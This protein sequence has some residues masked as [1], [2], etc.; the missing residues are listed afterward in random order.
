VTFF[1]GFLSVFPPDK[2]LSFH[3]LRAFSQGRLSARARKLLLLSFAMRHELPLGDERLKRPETIF[4]Y[5]F[6]HFARFGALEQRDRLPDHTEYC[7]VPVEAAQPGDLQVLAARAL[8]PGSEPLVIDL[9]PLAAVASVESVV[10]STLVRA[11]RELPSI[12]ELLVTAFSDLPEPATLRQLTGLQSLYFPFGTR[13]KLDLND[14]PAT[15]MLELMVTRW[16]VTSLAP[17]ERMTNLVSLRAELF[18][19]PLDTIARMAQLRLLI[20]RG[21]ARGWAKL[22][23]CTQLETASFAEVDMANLKRWNTW[24]SLR[25]LALTGRRLRSLAGLEASERL[26]RLTLVNLHTLDLAMLRELPHLASLTIRM[27]AGRIDLESIGRSP[28]LR[29]L[30]IDQNVMNDRDIAHVPTLRDLSSA[31]ALEDL[32]LIGVQVDDRDLLPL[33][34]LP[35]LRKV[36][37]GQ[38]IGADVDALRAARPELEVHY[39]RPPERRTDLAVR[40]GNVTINRP[41]DGIDTWWVFEDLAG[42]L[43][44]STNY[45]AEKRIRSAVKKR[46]PKLASRLEWDT[47]AGAVGI[48]AE[49][50]QDMRQVAEI[51]NDLAE[52]KE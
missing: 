32:V 37:L 10:A 45:A 17:L 8:T 36:R 50:E 44:T 52:R 51:V 24:K 35:Q 29:S 39:T 40:I 46:D 2:V 25:E 18:R 20:I 30:V 21:P 13:R 49:H 4:R 12:R 22:R 23:D 7:V 31:R 47:E 38:E 19:E 33:V 14:L 28:S 9:D 1:G 43:G 26:E 11:S 16:Q 27:P 15:Q 42:L 6:E 41:G 34:Q 5:R 48:Y 3:E